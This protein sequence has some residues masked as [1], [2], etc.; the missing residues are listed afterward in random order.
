MR[1]LFVCMQMLFCT[2]LLSQKKIVI[3]GSSTSAGFGASSYANSYVGKLQAWYN[4]NSADGL[5]TVFYN[6]AAPNLTTYNIMPTGYVPP[7]GR[8]EPIQ[9]RNITQALSYSPD[10]ILISM[11]SNDMHYMYTKKE[12]MDNLRA[13]NNIAV[14]SGVSCFITT[15]QPRNTLSTE[16][17]DS[18]RTLVDSTNINFGIYSVDFWTDIVTNDGQNLIRPEVSFGDGVHVNDLGHN[19]L[20]ERARAKNM[21]GS[22][23]PLPLLLKSF[24]V[25][26]GKDNTVLLKWQTESEELYTRFYPERSMDGLNFQTLTTIEGKAGS[27]N[28]YT[29]VDNTALPGKSFY[30]LRIVE[31]GITKYSTVKAVTVKKPV[32]AIKKIITGPSTLT[33]EIHTEKSGP[34]NCRVTNSAG[35]LIYERQDIMLTAP[36]G[37][38]EIPLKISSTGLYYLTLYSKEGTSTRSVIY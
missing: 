34:V 11:P 32:F 30:R 2:T 33:I 28:N 23:I 4:Q 10:V 35:A 8:P 26:P 12:S 13:V 1:Y 19:Y 27:L 20:Y 15:T 25:T 17:R 16:W 29:W 31:N 6:L 24:L 37:L 9:A 38:L 36:S 5:D 14:S 3:L 22:N 18:L 7:P 21:F